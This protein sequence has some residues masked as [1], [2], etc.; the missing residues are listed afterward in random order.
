MHAEEQFDLLT[1]NG[2]NIY[3]QDDRK[4]TQLYK[5]FY[6]AL[7]PN[8][9]LVT[10]FLTPSPWLDPTSPWE[11]NIINQSDLLRQ[12]II[13]SYIVQPKWQAYRTETKT[14]EQLKEAGFR[15]VQI[16]YDEYKMFPAVLA[17]K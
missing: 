16:I 17:L 9:V 12:K 5:T 6:T 13:Y 10:S 4:V 8:G 15:D 11:M 3:E 14:I 1:S 7:K 2:L